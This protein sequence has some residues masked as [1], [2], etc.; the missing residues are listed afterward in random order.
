[1]ARFQSFSEFYPFY[2]TEHQDPISVRLH[3]FGTSCFII[4]VMVAMITGNAWWL[5]AGPIVAYGC[6]W[7]GHYW[8]EKNKPATF[9]YPFWSLRGDFT[10]LYDIITG[11]YRSKL[12][13]AI[14]E[15]NKNAT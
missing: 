13:H 11:R 14:S 9:Q 15:Q 1:M 6:A 8:F 5:L 2:L 10:M 3:F 7:I 4:A 12:D